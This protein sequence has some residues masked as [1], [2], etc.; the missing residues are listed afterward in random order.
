LAGLK[1]QPWGLAWGTWENSESPSVALPIIPP[2]QTL[3]LGPDSDP[4]IYLR[5]S[6][7]HIL[8]LTS[9]QFCSVLC[10][11]G[12]RYHGVLVLTPYCVLE[13]PEAW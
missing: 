4:R 11:T 10:Q 5:E 13:S 8:G 7:F 9:H 12:H 3:S 6:W 2:S 1:H